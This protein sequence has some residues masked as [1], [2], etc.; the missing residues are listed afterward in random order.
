M[1]IRTPPARSSS[2]C[3]LALVAG[4]ALPAC[5]FDDTGMPGAADDTPDTDAGPAP[6]RMP[7]GY[8]E[9][10]TMGWYRV[11]ATPG[12]LDAARIDCD[13]DVAGAHLVVV[14][15]A[16]ENAALRRH[17]EDRLA[18]ARVW[19][20]ISDAAQEGTWRTV[21]NLTVD[22][23]DWRGGEPDDAGGS[24]CAVLLG[25]DDG[26]GNG[27]RWDDVPCAE[28]HPYVCE[29]HPPPGGAP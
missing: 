7:A 27:G 5:Y 17:A 2:A 21:D 15:D 6:G 19:L 22:F 28:A 25:A 23:T 8:E 12:G 1:R 9:L 3:A 20:G 13:D 10:G 4:A 11:V 29:W 16:A 18:G 24:D 14:D 26:P